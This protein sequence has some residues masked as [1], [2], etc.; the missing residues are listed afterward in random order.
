MM[1]SLMKILMFI[2]INE[3]DNEMVGVVVVMMVMMV[4]VVVMMVDH[5]WW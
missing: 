4:V 1:A 2:A 5:H 3:H